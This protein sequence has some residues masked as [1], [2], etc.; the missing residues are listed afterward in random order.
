MGGSGEFRGHLRCGEFRGHLTCGEFKKVSIA[1]ELYSTTAN[2]LKLPYCSHLRFFACQM[3]TFVEFLNI[4]MS[5]SE[6]LTDSTF[7]LFTVRTA[8][9]RMNRDLFV[10]AVGLVACT[11]PYQC[12]RH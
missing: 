4:E 12:M 11:V 6:M 9:A 3:L 10:L 8:E 7:Y 5:H 1:L 2:L